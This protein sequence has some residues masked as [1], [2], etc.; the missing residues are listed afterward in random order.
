MVVAADVRETREHAWFAL[1]R[2]GAQKTEHGK[3]VEEGPQCD[4][5]LSYALKH[6]SMVDV[7]RG[8]VSLFVVLATQ[9]N[10]S[11]RRCRLRGARTHGI[12]P[13][14]STSTIK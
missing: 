3:E 8:L 1:S 13:Y 10:F 7:L 2:R 5:P 14:V 6:A 4:H 11:R 9:G 12:T